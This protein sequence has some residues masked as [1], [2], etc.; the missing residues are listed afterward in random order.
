MYV[1][2]HDTCHTNTLHTIYVLNTAVFNRSKVCSELIYYR[3]AFASRIPPLSTATLCDKCFFFFTPTRVVHSISCT[4]N[5]SNGIV[6]FFITSSLLSL[7]H[8]FW[9]RYWCFFFRVHHNQ[10][11]YTVHIRPKQYNIYIIYLYIMCTCDV[12]GC[13]RMR[14]CMCTVNEW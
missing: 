7:S 2:V 6:F 12:Y 13:K 8:T 3:H 9:Y 10:C 11:V 4:Q 14:L 5:L 1:Y